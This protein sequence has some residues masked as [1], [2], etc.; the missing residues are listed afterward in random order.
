MASPGWDLQKSVYT[1]LHASVP[2]ETL[3]GGKRIYD[4]VPQD[5]VFPYV[6]IDQMQIRDWSTGTEKG[7]EHM[8]LLHVWSHY[9]GKREICEIGDALRNV[10]DDTELSLDDHRLVNLSHQY[11][12]LKR[13]I[14]GK[15]YHAIVRFR[16]I[17]EP[18]M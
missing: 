13:D 1:A 4:A 3:L 2:L 5:A 9:E 7:F 6:V 8:V 17:T 16:A 15:T 18:L 14:D 10:L 12:D 11:S